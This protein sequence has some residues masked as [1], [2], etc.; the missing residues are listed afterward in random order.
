MTVRHHIYTEQEA[1]QKL[2]ALCASAEYC[3]ADMRKK[4]REWVISPTHT[5]PQGE[6]LEDT[7]INE[8]MNDGDE[9]CNDEAKDEDRNDEAKDRIIARLYHEKFLDDLRYA[10]SFVH[11]KFR[12]NHWGRVRISQELRMR[13]IPSNIIE[14]AL[15]EIPEEDNLETLTLLIENKKKSV[16]GKSAYDIKCKLIRFALGRGFQMDDIIKVVGDVD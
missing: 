5:L 6:G 12:Y 9:G 8:G 10:T 16:K 1:Y 2:S 11:D 4:M 15:E 13:R 7:E 3:E 14:V